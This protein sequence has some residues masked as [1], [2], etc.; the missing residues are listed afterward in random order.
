MAVL[1]ILNYPSRGT[2]QMRGCF[3]LVTVFVLVMSSSTSTAV[4]G[5]YWRFY[6]S[7]DGKPAFTGGVSVFGEYSPLDHLESSVK[8]GVQLGTDSFL[9][10]DTSGDI[11]LTGDVVFRDQEHSPLH[12]KRLRLVYDRHLADRLSGTTVAGGYY[13]WRL[14][15]DDAAFI[16]SHYR[17]R[18][19]AVRAV[20]LAKIFGATA[21]AG[22]VSICLFVWSRRRP[23]PTHHG[24]VGLKTA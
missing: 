14:H 16:V 19:N 10:E 11:T 1:R 4:A 8:G 17:Q 23:R 20:Q 2:Q 3:L 9:D 24:A 5:G 22:A 6:I 18:A 15:P 12:M 21:F 13:D 7:V